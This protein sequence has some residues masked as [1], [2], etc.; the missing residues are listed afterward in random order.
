MEISF[1]GA[2]RGVTGSC[3]LLEAKDDAGKDHKLLFDCGMFQGTQFA[4]EWNQ[5]EFGFDPA[6]VE[7][8]FI[9]HP[10]IDHTGRLARLVSKGFNGVIHMTVPCLAL[11]KI[12]LDDAYHIMLENSKRNGEMVLYEREDL[13]GVYERVVTVGYHEQVEVGTGIKIM[14]HDAGHVLGS[15]FISVEAEGKKIVFS[16]DIGNDDVPILPDTEPIVDADIVVC[17]STYGDRLHENRA[18]RTD[19]LKQAI[20]NT[21]RNKSVLMIPA[22]S[23]ERTQELLYEL[24][25]I[26]LHDLKTNIPIF[27]DSPMAIQATQAYRDFKSYLRF[28]VPI[29]SDPDHDFFTF[30][31]LRETLKKEESKYINE[32]KAPKIIIA[33]SGMMSG[34]RIMHHLLRYLSDPDN[35][36]LIIGYQAH[37]TIGREILDGAKSVMIFRHEV[38]VNA[39][40]QS[41]GSFSAH[42]DQDKLTKWLKS[43]GGKAPSRIF[44]VHGE[45]DSKEVFAKRLRK[46]IGSKVD[47]PDFQTKYEI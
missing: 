43:E 36:L 29:H 24:N 35:T 23:I 16:G 40:V 44:L 41:I 15:S 17:E 34:G 19:K 21:I 1:H 37:G 46:E 30:P 9:T 11:S 33:G 38:E 6:S 47:V 20:E 12:V 28:D 3:H 32:V 26:L 31:N 8:V 5:D 39:K 10:H 2:A 4:S 18:E 7:H 14:F 27:L 22:F 25:D 13:A 42:G 45:E